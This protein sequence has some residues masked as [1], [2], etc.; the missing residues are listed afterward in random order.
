MGFNTVLLTGVGHLKDSDS[1]II[2]A[3]EDHSLDAAN[4]CNSSRQVT[5]IDSRWHAA[6]TQ[7]YTHIGIRI[8][9]VL[10]GEFS[11]LR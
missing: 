5:K 4:Y 2:V 11:D 6:T 10:N 1:T 3:T 9:E 8:E 7:I